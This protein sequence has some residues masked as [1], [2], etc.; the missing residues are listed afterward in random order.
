MLCCETRSEGLIARVL[1]NAN[2]DVALESHLLDN[3]RASGPTAR[4]ICTSIGICVGNRDEG[5]L[6]TDKGLL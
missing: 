4:E 6:P 5:T 2:A 1:L 3:L